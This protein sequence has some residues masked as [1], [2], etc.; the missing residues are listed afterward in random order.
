MAYPIED[1]SRKRDG[2]RESERERERERER[3]SSANV[4]A[5]AISCHQHRSAESVPAAKGTGS[6]AANLRTLVPFNSLI[7]YF[8]VKKITIVSGKG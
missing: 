1:L 3:S 2:K 8:G 6:R 5:R 4:C 7:F